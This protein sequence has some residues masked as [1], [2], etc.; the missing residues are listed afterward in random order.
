MK[1]KNDEKPEPTSEEVE[2]VVTQEDY[3]AG[4]KRG[5]DQMEPEEFWH[6]ANKN[7]QD[8]NIRLLFVADEIPSELQRIVEFLNEQMDQTEVLAIEIKQFVG[9][10]QTGLVPRVIGRTAEAQVKKSAFSAAPATVEEI[11]EVI[12]RRS[13]KEAELAERILDWSK[14]Y[15]TPKCSHTQFR[16]DLTTNPKS[17]HPVAIDN[18]GRLWTYNKN[19]QSIRPFDVAENWAEFRRRLDDIPG[20]NFPENDMYS[21]AKLSSLASDAALRSFLDVITWSIEQV[22]A[23]SLLHS[24]SSE[25]EPQSS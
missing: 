9:G 13:P 12:R 10:E 8:R 22:K 24:N 20:V 25:C 17:F 3:E 16:L 14:H 5:Y 6:M 1:N 21:S 15:F 4:L 23:V 18:G 19:I 7:L 2:L 11:I